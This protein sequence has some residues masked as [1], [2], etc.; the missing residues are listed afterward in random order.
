MNHYGFLAGDSTTHYLGS[1]VLYREGRQLFKCHQ[2]TEGASSET[3]DAIVFHGKFVK[4]VPKDICESTELEAFK[5]KCGGF[6]R[7]MKGRIV[8]WTSA[9]IYGDT[10]TIEMVEDAQ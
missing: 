1:A 9:K 3:V 6:V 8:S 10:V 7:E 2:S 5:I 4:Q